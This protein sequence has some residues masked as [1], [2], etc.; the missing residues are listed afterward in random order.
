MGTK[1][2]EKDVEDSKDEKFALKIKGMKMDDRHCT[3]VLC[4]LVFVIFFASCFAVT[5]LGVT[6]GNPTRIMTPFDSDGNQCGQ[7]E[8]SMTQVETDGQLQ[9]MTRDFSEYPY[10][11]FTDLATE[12]IQAALNANAGSL[13]EE[14][15]YAVCVKE[16][17]N[18]DKTEILTIDLQNQYT[19]AYPNGK[20]PKASYPSNAFMGYCVPDMRKSAELVSSIT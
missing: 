2:R 18:A 10:K 7:P 19:T 14:A 4:C 16:C 17:P 6:Q 8:Q 9:N 15:Y 5:G 13:S 12:G 3:D 11:Y 1:F 20:T